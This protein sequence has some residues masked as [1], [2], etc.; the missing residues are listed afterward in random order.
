MDAILGLDRRALGTS[1]VVR[2]SLQ[3]IHEGALDASSVDALA[4][5]V[6]IGP[7]HLHR[8]FVQRT[9]A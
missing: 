2:R 8:L 3:L 4:A 7:R 1:A 9:C 5:R 6:G